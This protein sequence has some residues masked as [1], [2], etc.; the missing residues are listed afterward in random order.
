MKTSIYVGS[1]TLTP[2]A[3][4]RAGDTYSATYA[5]TVWPWFPWNET[6]S[7]TIRVPAA[8]LDRLARGETVE[9]AGSGADKKGRPR[10]VSGR[11]QPADAKT[12]KLKL[13]IHVD[14]I[15]LIFN[16]TYKFGG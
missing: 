1:V 12:G 15:D 14:G 9:F 2:S 6:G 4:V 8:D 13:K 7:V 5:A 16:G 3:F 10:T 11:A